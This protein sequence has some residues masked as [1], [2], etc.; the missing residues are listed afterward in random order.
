MEL[1]LGEKTALV[2]ATG[3]AAGQPP[4]S[5]NPRTYYS[6]ARPIFRSVQIVLYAL[7]ANFIIVTW[8]GRGRSTP[9]HPAVM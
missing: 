1:G 8:L 5:L 9:G 3:I 6:I 4:T 2:D 7:C